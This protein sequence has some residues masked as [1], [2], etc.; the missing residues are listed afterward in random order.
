MSDTVWTS[1]STYLEG[2]ILGMVVVVFAAM[3][4][5]VL[6]LEASRIPFPNA[7]SAETSA[8]ASTDTGYRIAAQL[9]FMTP[10]EM[11]RRS[12]V[13][14]TSPMVPNS[15]VRIGTAASKMASVVAVRLPPRLGQ[16]T[17]GS[18]R[19]VRVRRRASI[20][21]TCR[22]S[23]AIDGWSLLRLTLAVIGRRLRRLSRLGGPPC[24]DIQHAGQRLAA[25][26]FPINHS[27]WYGCH[28]SASHRPGHDT[29]LR[30]V[31]RLACR[32]RC[33][34]APAVC[35]SH[36]ARARRAAAAIHGELS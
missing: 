22:L 35:Y 20:K 21:C 5:M 8:A 10:E 13:N 24:G 19:K 4:P 34:P 33:R 9:D 17:S 32:G 30:V 14:W 28:P 3:E 25:P 31:V 16:S 11:R 23:T 18:R 2:M 15:L 36:L 7:T 12:R 26:H 1:L 29:L 27:V 6:A